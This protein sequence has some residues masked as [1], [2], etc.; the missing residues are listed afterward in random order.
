VGR[1]MLGHDVGDA[2]TVATPAGERSY[3]ILAIE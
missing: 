3:R 1:A 2:V